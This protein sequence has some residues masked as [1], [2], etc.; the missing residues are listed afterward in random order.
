MAID[1]SI[2]ELTFNHIAFPPKLPGQRDSKVEDVDRDILTRLGT[3]VQTI[4][5]FTDDE[6]TSVWED[7]EE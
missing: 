4:K 1:S 6:A 7:I 2:L 3:A 5:S